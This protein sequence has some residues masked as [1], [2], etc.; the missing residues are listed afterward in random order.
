MISTRIRGMTVQV[1]S[2][3][4]GSFTSLGMGFL[5]LLYLMAKPN[6]LQPYLARM[7]IGPL[8]ERQF[9][10]SAARSA[11]RIAFVRGLFVPVPLSSR[12]RRFFIHTD[13]RKIS[14]I[15]PMWNPHITSRPTANS[16]LQVSGNL[17]AK[18][19]SVL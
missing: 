18:P 17:F 2:R 3:A 12:S 10:E 9:T 14:S 16:A 4:R 19:A 11:K 5:F 1:I 7:R 8:S 15:C 6:G 13:C